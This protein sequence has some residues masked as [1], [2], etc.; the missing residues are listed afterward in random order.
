[1]IEGWG[2]D[3]VARV[4]RVTRL[5]RLH[6][7]PRLDIATFNDAIMVNFSLL[8]M[9]PLNRPAWTQI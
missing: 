2:L 9:V 3:R 7:L 4:T 8:V 5:H 6:R 1:M